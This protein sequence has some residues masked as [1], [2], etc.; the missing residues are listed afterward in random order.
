[1]QQ[2]SQHPPGL[3]RLTPRHALARP[4]CQ[5][6]HLPRPSAPMR[7]PSA[8]SDRSAGRPVCPSIA[9]AR[10]R[11]PSDPYRVAIERERRHLP[12]AALTRDEPIPSPLEVGAQRGHHADARQYTRRGTQLTPGRS[13]AAWDAERRGDGEW[14][15]TAPRDFV[16]WLRC[17]SHPHPPEGRA[18]GWHPGRVR[19]A[20][21]LFWAAGGRLDAGAICIEA[22]STLERTL[23]QHLTRKDLV[24][25]P[26]TRFGARNR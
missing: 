21:R 11:L 18:G 4:R 3:W 26:P 2:G 9:P 22:A 23:R 20:H 1:M 5:V 10:T 24:L 8:R 19:E 15:R 6:G 14:K 25:E 12:G 17:R 13:L 16:G 7:W